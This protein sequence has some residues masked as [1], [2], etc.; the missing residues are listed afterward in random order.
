M[1]SAEANGIRIEYETFGSRAGRPLVLV[2][3]LGSQLLGYHED[4][5]RMLVGLGHFVV[6]F[7]NR[8][9]GLST[10]LDEAGI[11]SLKAI[12]EARRR[13]EPPPVPYLL[14]AMADD[15]AGL[16]DALSLGATHVVGTSMGGMI[17]Q[18]FAIRHPERVLSL[19]SI[20]STTGNPALPPSRPEAL[21]R[22]TTPAPAERAAYV[23][24]Y[25]GSARVFGSPPPYFEEERI[26]EMAGRAFDR[27]FY[28]PG[29][30][31]QYAAIVASGSRKEALA[32]VRAPALV[33][34]G[35][36][37]PLV[38]VEGGIDTAA[39]I[40]GAELLIVEGMAHD[41]PRALWPRLTEAIGRHTARVPA[42]A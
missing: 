11:P 22:L 26:R 9:V 21:A 1:A 3:G 2:S 13:G 40:P 12:S 39:A 27:A 38:P 30:A 15:L 42:R 8:D 28:P 23:E 6:R 18:A 31:R 34:H 25:V 36:L 37:D 17:V 16:L 35:A 14:G 4:L 19:T 20:M 41:L 5:C 33:I 10:R 24:H 29:T 32:A 7:D